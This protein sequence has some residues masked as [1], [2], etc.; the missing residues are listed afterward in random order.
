MGLYLECKNRVN[1]SS[2]KFTYDVI[3]YL[4]RWSLSNQKKQS[5]FEIVFKYEG[6][7]V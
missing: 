5:T 2:K 1:F 7:I 6:Y 3:F 4:A